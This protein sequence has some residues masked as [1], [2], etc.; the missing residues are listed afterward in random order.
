[1]MSNDW[2]LL[3]LLKSVK[4][5]SHKYDEDVEYHHVAHHMLI[6]RFMLFCQG[7]YINSKYK[8]RFKEKIELLEEYNR[9]GGYSVT[10]RELRRKRS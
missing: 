5:L 8:K 2:E 3:G 6:Y 10:V 4:S 1:M 7:D 9:G